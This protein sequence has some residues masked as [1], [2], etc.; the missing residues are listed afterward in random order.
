M[1]YDNARKSL[2]SAKLNG[3]KPLLQEILLMNPS[4]DIME[5][6]LTTP[7]FFRR[8]K[9]ITPAASCGGNLGTT[10]RWALEHHLC[11]EGSIK[12]QDLREG[13]V[14][15]LSNGVRGWGWGKLDLQS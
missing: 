13:E 15:W 7:Y 11:A 3:D 6:S 2:P 1:V 10:R 14:I 12:D 9:W 8:G 4:R 5:G